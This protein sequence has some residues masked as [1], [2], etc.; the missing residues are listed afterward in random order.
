[1]RFRHWNRRE[2]ISLVGSAAAWPPAAR[3]QQA[4]APVV[5]FLRSSPEAGFG[6]FV[7]AFRQGL[8]EAGYVE[9]RNLSIEFRWASDLAGLPALA[10]DLVRHQVTVIVANY[11]AMPAVMAATTTIPIVFVSGEDPVTGGLVT[12]L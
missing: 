8:S 2:F 1:M 12:S 9:G 11:G 6:H 3:A 4:G 10:A 5:G 7:A